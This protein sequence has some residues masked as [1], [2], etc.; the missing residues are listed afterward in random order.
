[1]ER[2]TLAFVVSYLGT[3]AGGWQRQAHGNS[4]QD[5]IETA[6]TPI[7]NGK[8]PDVF[9]ASRTDVGVHARMQLVAADVRSDILPRKWV[10]ALNDSLP[11]NVRV[12]WAAWAPNGFR[13]R[14]K[15]GAKTYCYRFSFAPTPDPFT[16]FN[17]WWIPGKINR[18]PMTEL[19]AYWLGRHDFAAA[20]NRGRSQSETTI[21]TMLR[22]EII[23]HGDLTDYW[24]SS[25][26]FLTHQVRIMAGTLA[27]LAQNNLDLP[28]VIAAFERKDRRG[29]GQT[30][31]AHGL[32]LEHI[33]MPPQIEWLD[34]WPT[35][36]PPT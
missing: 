24:V 22:S 17:T 23:H 3:A 12:R 5:L 18:A 33:V 7:H 35:P 31:P 15:V 14:S 4:I 29:L 1:M 19:A 28:K 13:P 26:G 32:T 25:S 21:R 2:R 11:D 16:A 9:G 8:R 30:A 6:L 20:H 36:T 27:A 10:R 34:A